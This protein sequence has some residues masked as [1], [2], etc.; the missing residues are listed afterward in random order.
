M[1]IVLD[2]IGS[3]YFGDLI[4]SAKEIIALTRGEMISDVTRM[5][6]T[7]VYLGVRMQGL[8]EEYEEENECEAEED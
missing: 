7:R 3:D 1:R 2:K 5:E 6:K 8:W 4:V